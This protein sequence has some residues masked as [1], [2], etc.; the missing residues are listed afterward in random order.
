LNKAFAEQDPDV[1]DVLGASGHEFG[2]RK[3]GEF[4]H[5]A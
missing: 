5:S 2:D 1:L 4:R 3:V